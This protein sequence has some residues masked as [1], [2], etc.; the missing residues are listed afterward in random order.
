[1]DDITCH[2][3]SSSFQTRPFLAEQVLRSSLMAKPQGHGQ[4]CG[5]QSRTAYE[6]SYT[7]CMSMSAS[8]EYD[9][10]EYSVLIVL[11][12]ALFIRMFIPLEACTTPCGG[13][14]IESWKSTEYRCPP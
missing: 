11:Y 3:F 5:A 9:I 6:E 1:M 4:C 14:V 8:T 7:V 13:K 10:T 12:I 2:H